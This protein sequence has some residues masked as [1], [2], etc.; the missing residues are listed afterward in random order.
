MA[1]VDR[2]HK[3]IADQLY[4]RYGRVLEAEHPG[5]HLAICPGGQTVISPVLIDV[6]QQARAALGP[7][8]F[9]FKVGERAVW[10]WR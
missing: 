1:A 5:E 9:V 7:G 4:D 6:M 2:E 8:S 3:H 10:K